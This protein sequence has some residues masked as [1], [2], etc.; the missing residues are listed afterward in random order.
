M[1]EG[2][3]RNVAKQ[4]Y[5]NSDYDGIDE[6]DVI[7]PDQKPFGWKLCECKHPLWGDEHLFA[8]T[9]AEKEI[10]MSCRTHLRKRENRC[11]ICGK[12]KCDGHGGM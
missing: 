11:V 1:F 9:E 10:C 5:A 7:H 3:S 12:E 2:I 6:V 8:V 4:I